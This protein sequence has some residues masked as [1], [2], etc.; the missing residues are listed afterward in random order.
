MRSFRT[1]ETT[2]FGYP[3]ERLEN[4]DEL[5]FTDSR[6]FE[7]LSPDNGSVL[8][9]FSNRRDAESFVLSRERGF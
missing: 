4:K 9:S 8:A 3:I 6:C 1:P 5:G 7:V 2:I